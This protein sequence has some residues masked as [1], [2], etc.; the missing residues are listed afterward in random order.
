MCNPDFMAIHSIAVETRN[1]KCQPHGG[2]RAKVTNG[3]FILWGPRICVQ[4]KIAI[5]TTVIYLCQP[6]LTDTIGQRESSNCPITMKI[7]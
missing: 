5:H 7:A 2:A 3:C 4:N 6:D 1:H